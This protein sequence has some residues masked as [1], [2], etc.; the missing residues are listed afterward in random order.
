M[1]LLQSN[2]RVYYKS[3]SVDKNATGFLALLHFAKIFKNAL[4]IP[5]HNHH[6]YNHHDPNGQV[7]EVGGVRLRSPDWPLVL[8]L[9]LCLTVTL[10]SLFTWLSEAT[11][12]RQQWVRRREHSHPPGGGGDSTRTEPPKQLAAKLKKRSPAARRQSRQLCRSAA[13]LK[14]F[15]A[16]AQYS[17]PAKGNY[18]YKRIKNAPPTCVRGTW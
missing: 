5:V 7:L 17:D 1:L 2:G 14:G 13:T 16:T 9:R 8:W 4:F 18:T 15:T 6:H 3:D 11:A 12:D 10:S